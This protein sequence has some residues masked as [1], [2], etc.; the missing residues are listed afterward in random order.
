MSTTTSTEA[1]WAVVDAQG[2]VVL[3]C[4]GKDGAAAASEWVE[5]GYT[6]EPVEPRP[7]GAA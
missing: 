5:R 4:G 1:L 3:I 2:R 6:V 7:A